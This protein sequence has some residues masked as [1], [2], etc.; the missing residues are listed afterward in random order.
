VSTRTRLLAVA[1]SAAVLSLAGAGAAV[2][3]EG[4]GDFTLSPGANGGTT[5]TWQG[6]EGNGS[7]TF[8]DQDNFRGSAQFPDEGPVGY[9]GTVGG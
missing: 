5:A 8:F 4:N 7:I 2:A 6:A 3:D 9:R 1:A